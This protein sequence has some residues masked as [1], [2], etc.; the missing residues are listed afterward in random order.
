[1]C[2]GTSGTPGRSAGSS[3]TENRDSASF[4]PDSFRVDLRCINVTTGCE[5]AMDIMGYFA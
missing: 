2:L 1:M 5:T 3:S 4:I